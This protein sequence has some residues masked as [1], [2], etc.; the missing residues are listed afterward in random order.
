MQRD[1]YLTQLLYRYLVYSNI[2]PDKKELQLILQSAPSFPSVLSIIQTCIYFGLKTNGYRANYDALLKS[3]MPVIAHLRTD[4]DERFVLITRTTEE[5]VRYVDYSVGYHT[6]NETKEQF[7]TQWTGV[8]IVSN[9]STTA[10]R[11]RRKNKSTKYI[12]PCGLCILAVLFAILPRF[13]QNSPSEISFFAISLFLLKGFGTWITSQLIRYEVSPYYSPFDQFCHLYKSFDCEE[14][15]RSKASKLLNVMPL[16]DTGFIYFVTGISALILSFL[17]GRESDILP[18][19]FCLS[20]CCVPYVLFS[21][22]YQKFVVKKWCPL[23]LSVMGLILLETLLFLIYPPKD[24]L[25]IAVLPTLLMLSSSLIFAILTSSV[26]HRLLQDEK[27]TFVSKL[28]N[29]RLK[30]NPIILTTIFN[31]REHVRESS[32]HSITIG[33]LRYDTMTIT[34]L[35][36]PKCIPCKEVATDV[37]RMMKK[38][39]ARFLWQICFDGI[40]TE[41]YHP[42][43]QVQLHLWE[44]CRKETNDRI[45][46]QIINDWFS[47][48][49]PQWFF[50]KYPIDKIS[51][52][53]IAE[54]SIQCHEN[55][56]L[57]ISKVPAIWVDRKMLPKEYVISDLP[58]LCIDKSFI[59]QS[60]NRS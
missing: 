36:N 57:E 11:E 45:K 31:V 10:D 47:K 50:K 27:D 1:N 13:I 46:L 16:S 2:Y 54:F 41:E 17:L 58:I 35:L 33:N 44:L 15:L 22:L 5:N 59:P 39:P 21:V 29:M 8:L 7:C 6:I 48:Q 40:E 23:C 38:F 19:L 24:I 32:A 30:R 4:E 28:E 60:A 37:I 20:A 51:S 26:Y 12:A 9:R 18:V 3:E 53:T 56:L 34:T 14:V 55:K 42:M 49:S 43:N 25:R 52:D